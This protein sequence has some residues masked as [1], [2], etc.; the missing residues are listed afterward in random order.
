MFPE[1][2]IER[3]IALVGGR[4]CLQPGRRDVHPTAGPII[5]LSSIPAL[6]R[7]CLLELLTQ[8]FNRGTIA[9]R[10]SVTPSQVLAVAIRVKTGAYGKPGVSGMLWNSRR[11]SWFPHLY[12]VADYY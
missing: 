2:D 8:G 7:E 11:L 6:G 5:S 12:S 1:A 3:P 10:V 4:A 9:A